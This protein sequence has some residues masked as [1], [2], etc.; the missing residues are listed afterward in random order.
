GMDIL[1]CYIEELESKNEK[2][3][4]GEKAF[5]LYDTYGFPLELTQE[6]VEEKGLT[7]DIEGFNAE[8]DN[9]RK[10]ARAA[11]GDSSYMGSDDGVLNKIPLEI[12]LAIL[13][14]GGFD[15]KSFIYNNYYIYG[16]YFTSVI[17]TTMRIFILVLTLYILLKYYNN[18]DK[19]SDM[20]KNT[21]IY[22]SFKVVK[23]LSK[24]GINEFEKI[25]KLSKEIPLA[26]RLLLIGIGCLSINAIGVLF[27]PF[28]SHIF[29]VIG[30]TIVLT[31]FIIYTIKKLD[32]INEIMEGT[33]KI[34][35]GNI[36]YKIPIKG[37]NN[38]TVLAENINNI[39]QGLE[40][41]IHNQLKSERM[42][43]ELITNVSHDLKTPL[44]SIINYVELI[45]KEENIEP[46]HIKE[47]I[48]V[49]D[50]K[51]RRLKILI[52]DLFEASK[53]GSGSIELNMEKI[54][55]NQLLRQI[56]GEMEQKLSTSN[57]DIKLN[58]PEE[59]IYINADGKRMYR[60]FENLLS[61]ISKYSL[62]GTRVYIDLKENE[63]NIQLSMKNISSYELNFDSSEIMERFKR[64]DKSRNT[65]GSG[66]GLAIAKDLI[67]LQGGQFNIDIDGDLFK[68]TI[69]FKKYYIK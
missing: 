37:N 62:S 33:K 56:I 69:E 11:R 14:I 27:G 2:T 55:L 3:L 31:F 24:K 45:K 12:W 61:N 49:L 67:N 68:A 8:M 4:S 59:K 57:L 53:V 16:D 10:T 19:K 38:F 23:L 64:G 66:L 34:K 29:T 18:Y 25:I 32:Y 39:G 58:I 9:Q 20:L 26:R 21:I 28:I 6:I 54:E 65:E 13:V 1:K 63:D 44:T 5:K 30:S 60:V 22:K 48:N 47:Y 15:V 52:E 35:E 36:N 51:S 46:Q 40:N 41:S 17:I 7:I 50:S 42:K 43:S